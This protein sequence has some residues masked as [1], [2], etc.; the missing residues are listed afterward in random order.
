MALCKSKMKVQ[1]VILENLQV[2]HG[3]PWGVGRGEEGAGVGVRHGGKASRELREHGGEEAK[4]C[5]DV[6]LELLINSF[7][8]LK[9]VAKFR[10]FFIKI[11]HKF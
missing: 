2:G 9:I 7:H 6:S 1:I 5:G 3:H 11:E 8:F 4:S 10:Q